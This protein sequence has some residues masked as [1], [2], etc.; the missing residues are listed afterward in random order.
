MDFSATLRHPSPVATSLW[1][2]ATSP[3]P[4]D[5]AT[6]CAAAAAFSKQ[7]SATESSS[8]SVSICDE[9][10]GVTGDFATPALEL[11]RRGSRASSLGVPRDGGR[12]SSSFGLALTGAD[13]RACSARGNWGL[14]TAAVVIGC[15][16][17]GGKTV[18]SGL[19]AGVCWRYDG[20][21]NCTGAD[22]VA[23]A[24]GAGADWGTG[25]GWRKAPL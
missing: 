1:C 3:A 19:G 13:W 15:G 2:S 18:L 21:T 11:G 10:C 25:V 24:A 9:A 16:C 20:S 23:D 22:M 14:L 17:D 6:C 8:G 12:R 5:F 4:I 7:S